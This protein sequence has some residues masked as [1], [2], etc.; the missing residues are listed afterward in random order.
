VGGPETILVVEDHT[1]VRRLACR[2]LRDLGYTVLEAGDVEDALAILETEPAIDLVFSDIVMPGE[3]NGYDLARW[4]AAHRPAIQCLLATGY[5]DPTQTA[6]ADDPTL[7][8]VLFKPYSQ[9]QLTQ[10][11]RQALDGEAGTSAPPAA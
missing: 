7:P 1:R 3:Q 5:H 9:D 6:L 10:R 2:Y 4:V 8:P 11:V